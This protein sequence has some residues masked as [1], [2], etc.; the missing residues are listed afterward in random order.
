[1]KGLGTY[2]KCTEEEKVELLF[3]LYDL[4]DDGF[5]QKKELI[6]MVSFINNYYVIIVALQFSK[7][8]SQKYN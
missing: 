2:C 8:L 1:L 7:A 6:T 3:G 5:I 4:D